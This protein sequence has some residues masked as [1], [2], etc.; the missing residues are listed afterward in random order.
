MTEIT[1]TFVEP[2][3]SPEPETSAPPAPPMA[4][5]SRETEPEE[6]PTRKQRPRTPEQ[7]ERMSAAAKASWARRK[8]GKAGQ[9]S[10]EELA[11]AAGTVDSSPE[12]DRVPGKPKRGRGRQKGTAAAKK[13][14]RPAIPPFRAGLI[15]KGM[16][17]LYRRAGK[18]LRAWDRDLG[19]ALI[20]CT[21]AEDEDDL[22][23]GQ[24]W[25]E[26]ARTNP[27]L[28]AFLMKMI[29]GGAWSDLFMAHLPILLAILA[30]PAVQKHLPF[31]RLAES[32]LAD[33]GEDE[34]GEMSMS[35]AF[36]GITPEDMQQAAAF[37]A[38]QGFPGLGLRVPGP[39]ARAPEAHQ[40]GPPG[41]GGP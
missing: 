23:V 4:E 22:T 31:A 3:S 35:A 41:E 18:L 11:E 25:E 13:D 21:R 16:D 20:E 10:P 8:A 14:G 36:G 12:P 29:S 28:R 40:Y 7:R 17:R 9:P 6:K 30:K 33:D 15:A 37:M 5:V 39:P 2:G 24:A 1:A 32:V 19:Q 26:I 38:S 27:R 34:A